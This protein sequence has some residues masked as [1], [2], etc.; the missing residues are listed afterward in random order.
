MNS[1]LIVITFDDADDALKVVEAMQSMRK[2]PLFNLDHSVVVIR[3]RMG[4][5]RLHQTRDVTVNG[6][7]TNGDVLGLLAGLIFG[8][9]MGVVWGVVVDE[10]ILELTQQGLDDKFV[11]V[12][13]QS[14]GNNTSAIL[15]LVHRDD[16]SDRDEILNVLSQFKGKLHYTTISPETERYLVQVLAERKTSR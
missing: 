6:S 15:F 10:A 1:D 11:Q 12:V 14:L 7:V 5:V 13:E 3:D 16:R 9:T 4:K 8:T 2:E